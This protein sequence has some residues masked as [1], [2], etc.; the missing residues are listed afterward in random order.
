MEP[1]IYPVKKPVRPNGK[2]EQ[3]PDRSSPKIID[4]EDKRDRGRYKY[5]HNIGGRPISVIP[6]LFCD[7]GKFG[8]LDDIYGGR[9][10]TWPQVAQEMGSRG[11]IWTALPGRSN[12]ENEKVEEEAERGDA[13]DD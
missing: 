11:L 1:G 10:N 4:I 12:G 6:Y 9:M 8:R 5:G 2:N 7:L 13:K 3:H